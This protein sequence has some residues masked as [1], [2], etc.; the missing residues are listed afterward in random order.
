M[1]NLYHIKWND[2]RRKSVTEIPGLFQ[3]LHVEGWEAILV[4]IVHALE[5]A[6]KKFTVICHLRALPHRADDILPNILD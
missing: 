4:V 2:G 6:K 3:Y 1:I 5:R